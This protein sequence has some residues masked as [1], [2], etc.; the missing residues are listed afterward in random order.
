MLAVIAMWLPTASHAEVYRCGNSYSDEPC[1]GGSAIQLRGPMEVHGEEAADVFLCRQ[2]THQ[3]WSAQSC[4]QN[5]ATIMRRQKVPATWTWEQQRKYA[6]REWLRAQRETSSPA[7]ITHHADTSAAAQRE[8]E[9]PACAQA[10]Q[11]IRQLDEM[12]RRGGTV[13]YMERVRKE[14]K[15]ARDWQFRA[16]C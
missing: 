16:G 11:R 5:N 6:E 10:D 9:K 14:R 3:F 7:S 4:Q 8:R 12:A 15:E 2:G 13:R 1:P